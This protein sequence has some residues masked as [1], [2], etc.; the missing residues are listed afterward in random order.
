MRE[1][2]CFQVWRPLRC[3]G[4]CSF[5][6]GRS[7]GPAVEGA[8]SSICRC[9]STWVLCERK[10][11]PGISETEA[12]H[13]TLVSSC[14]QTG[15]QHAGVA[16]VALLHGRGGDGALRAACGLPQGVD[17]KRGP[18][19]SAPVKGKL[20]CRCIL[21]AASLL[22]FRTH[23]VSFRSVLVAV[24]LIQLAYVEHTL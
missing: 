23:Q 9:P 22:S 18:F 4:T 15:T 1:D 24:T 7:E 8:C 17:E 5:C 11:K 3:C 13:R 12:I 16:A 20:F 10:G 6:C 19:P 14:F 21:W 2:L